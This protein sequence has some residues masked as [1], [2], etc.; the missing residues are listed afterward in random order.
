MSFCWKISLHWLSVLWYSYWHCIIF[1]HYITFLYVI[2]MI[3]IK[4]QLCVS[5]PN[6]TGSGSRAKNRQR[7]WQRAVGVYLGSRWIDWLTDPCNVRRQKV[8][9]HAE[10]SM[11]SARPIYCSSLANHTVKGVLHWTG[12]YQALFNLDLGRYSAPR[13]WEWKHLRESIT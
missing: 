2:I 5:V 10:G 7:H 13:P 12:S 1:I 8:L 4:Q 6:S 9:S 11:S 3:N